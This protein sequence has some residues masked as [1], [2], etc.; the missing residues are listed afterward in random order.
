MKSRAFSNQGG[1]AM[2]MRL[3]VL[4]CLLFLSFLQQVAASGSGFVRTRG[5]HF[6]VNGKPMFFNGFNSYWLM[7]VAMDLTQRNKVTSVFQQAATLRL[8]V[9]RTWAFN[10]GQYKALQIFPGV[11][12]EKVFQVCAW[13]L[14]YIKPSGTQPIFF[15]EILLLGV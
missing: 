7:T 1:G 8:N 6:N 13:G 2:T 14:H 15:Q 4:S 5:T 10:D 3:W 9:A 11:Y 12:D